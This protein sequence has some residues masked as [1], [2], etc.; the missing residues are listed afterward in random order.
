MLE[1]Q[2][3]IETAVGRPVESL[4]ALTSGEVEA[5]LTKLPGTGGDT[6]AACDVIAG[7]D[8]EEGTWI[9]RL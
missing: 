2:Q 1:R 7:D 3:A 4:R 6:R 8:R 5:V 9:D